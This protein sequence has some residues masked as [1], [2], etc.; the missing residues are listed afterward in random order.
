MRQ[1]PAWHLNSPPDMDPTK[2]SKGDAGI[3][4]YASAGFQVHLQENSSNKI[5]TSTLPCLG[6]PRHQLSTCGFIPYIVGEQTGGNL[7]FSQ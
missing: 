5:D 7:F 3:L 4:F 6:K 2:R 1:C